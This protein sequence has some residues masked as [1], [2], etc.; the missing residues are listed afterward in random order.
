MFIVNF[1]HPSVVTGDLAGDKCSTV[2]R[3]QERI[4]DIG[5]SKAHVLRKFRYTTTFYIPPK[6]SIS[7]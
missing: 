1:A 5:T 7:Y 2:L 3:R 6:H 4:T